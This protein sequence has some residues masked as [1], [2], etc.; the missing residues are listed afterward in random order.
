[1]VDTFN[2]EAIAYPGVMD[3]EGESRGG[4]SGP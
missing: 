4:G 2:L 3:V 1:M